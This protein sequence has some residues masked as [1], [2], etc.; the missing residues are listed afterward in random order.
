MPA[1][2]RIQL[3]RAG[4]QVRQTWPVTPVSTPPRAHG[5]LRPDLLFR[6]G[7]VHHARYF[8]RAPHRI[9]I[10][11]QVVIPLVREAATEVRPDRALE[12][13][14][15]DL[16]HLPN[17]RVLLRERGCIPAGYLAV[18]PLS[19]T[20][21]CTPEDLCRPRIVHSPIEV[22]NHAIVVSGEISRRRPA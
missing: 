20:E 12:V 1:G 7:R 4:T 15:D 5:T 14:I 13:R 6:F 22:Q 2:C 8:K 11:R 16:H 18:A 10:T 3:D 17:D 21:P 9:H 19:H